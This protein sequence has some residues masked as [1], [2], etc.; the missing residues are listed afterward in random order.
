M[1]KATFTPGNDQSNLNRYQNYL[2]KQVPVIWQ[3][4]APFQIAVVN[5]KLK[6]FDYDVFEYLNPSDWY[7]TK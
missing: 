7:L 3:A 6:G 2:T 4:I 5:S 1:I